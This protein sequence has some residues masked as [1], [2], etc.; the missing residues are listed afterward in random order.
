MPQIMTLSIDAIKQVR[1][2]LKL[3]IIYAIYTLV[4]DAKHEKFKNISEQFKSIYEYC[5]NLARVIIR[6]TALYNCILNYIFK[7]EINKY[8]VYTN[9]K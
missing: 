2:V 9:Q 4:H 3:L 8:L 1:Y 7:I 6:A 5:Q